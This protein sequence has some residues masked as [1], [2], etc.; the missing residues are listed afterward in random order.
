MASVVSLRGE[1]IYRRARN[2]PHNPITF[3]DIDSAQLNLQDG[4][5]PCSALIGCTGSA[6]EV[7]NEGELWAV[8]G[9]EV[10]SRLLPGW[11]TTPER[12]ILCS[13]IPTE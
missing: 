8:T 2:R 7:H 5:F 13:F 1:I 4:A 10:W 3:A 6:T 11:A 12:F 9:F